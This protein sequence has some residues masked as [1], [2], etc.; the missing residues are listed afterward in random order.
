[1]RSLSAIRARA[2]QEAEPMTAV[3]ADLRRT[4]AALHGELTRNGLVAWTSG[5]H[6]G[7]RAGQELIVIKPSGVGYDELTAESMVVVDLHGH[8]R[9]GRALAVQ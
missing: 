5:E 2:S 7:A 8:R 3:V 9:R 1:M 6:L 4:V